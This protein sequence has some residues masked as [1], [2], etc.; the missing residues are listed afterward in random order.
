[1][2]EN[3][4]SKAPFNAVPLPT[5]DAIPAQTLA[6][7][8]TLPPLNV[9]R[10]LTNVPNSLQ[11]FIELARSFLNSDEF[12]M[13]QREIA[14][15]RVAHLTHSPYESHQHTLL[16]KSAGMTESEIAIIN[17]E[18]PVT[19][20]NEEENLICLVADELSLDVNLT[21]TTFHLLFSRYSTKKAGE[22]ILN[23]SFYNMLSRFLNATRTQIEENNPL[24]GRSSPT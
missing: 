6:F 1:M 13:R 22:L 10:M 23:I 3:L 4:M 16:A 24:E 5:D 12:T 8:Q 15:L 19:S 7:L 11:P 18:H 17:S 21:E 14:I 2:G 9:Y 20:L